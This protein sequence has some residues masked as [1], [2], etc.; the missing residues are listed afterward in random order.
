MFKSLIVKNKFQKLFGVKHSVFWT[1]LSFPSALEN[2]SIS[3]LHF[4][5]LFNICIFLLCI[6]S[7]FV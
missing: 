7:S 1:L 2:S 5:P 4:Y 6:L 3:Y